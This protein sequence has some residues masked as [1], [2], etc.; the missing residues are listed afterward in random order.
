MQYFHFISLK[1]K[2]R[3]TSCAVTVLVASL[4]TVAI[5][6]ANAALFFGNNE[7]VEMTSLK[8][9]DLPVDQ[10]DKITTNIRTLAKMFN[11]PNATANAV[12]GDGI[13]GD[14]VISWVGEKKLPT[15][16]AS[17]KAVSSNKSRIEAISQALDPINL[18]WRIDAVTG[19]LV[20][21]RERSLRAIPTTGL[22][23]SVPVLFKG[24]PPELNNLNTLPLA[25]VAPV[26]QPPV[27]IVQ[28]P[29]VIN[30]PV[31]EVKVT[32]VTLSNTFER[33]ARVAGYTLKWDVDKHIL[34]DAPNSIKSNFEGALASVLSSPG[35]LMSDY[36]LEVC[37]YPNTPPL[38]RITKL[39]EQKNQCK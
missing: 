20:I 39:G 17:I 1:N 16:N 8:W 9:F 11:P 21:E 35:I 12:I 18:N 4:M 27:A 28:P 10:G 37:F 15:A 3:K 36:P 22:T 7:S 38:A 6:P 2:M 29:P 31:W 25:K 24:V 19:A 30:L 23:P 34:I 32:D 13:D 5:N 26:A 14:Q 33:W